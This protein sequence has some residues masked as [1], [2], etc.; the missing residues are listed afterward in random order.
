[1]MSP[2]RSSKIFVDEFYSQASPSGWKKD[3]DESK[4]LWNQI[5]G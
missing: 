5:I 2:L 4:N 1:M 3:Y